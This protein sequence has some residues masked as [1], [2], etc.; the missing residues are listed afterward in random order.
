L[1]LTQCKLKLD[2]DPQLRTRSPRCQGSDRP[3]RHDSAQDLARRGAPPLHVHILHHS[4]VHDLDLRDELI[5]SGK[6]PRVK[7]A[8]GG[9]GACKVDPGILGC[10]RTTWPGS[11]VRLP[12]DW[13]SSP[14]PWPFSAPERHCS[15][16]PRMLSSSPASSPSSPTVSAK[17]SSHPR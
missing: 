16:L 3:Q 13:S 8:K 11:S 5:E 2:L 9:L 10:C 6:A 1:D 4:S 14:A 15:R 12:L 17:S 7:S